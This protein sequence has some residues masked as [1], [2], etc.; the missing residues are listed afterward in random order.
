MFAPTQA[1]ISFIGMGS[2]EVAV[3]YAMEQL[4][5]NGETITRERVAEIAQC[6]PRT[7]TKVFSVWRKRGELTMSGAPRLGYT[8]TLTQPDNGDNPH[9]R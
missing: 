6:T 9:D 2:T 3:R 7:V 8:Y 1:P 4:L 5:R